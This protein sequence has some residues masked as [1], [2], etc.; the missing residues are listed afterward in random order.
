MGAIKV[1]SYQ[2]VQSLYAG[3]SNQL[4]GIA[5][6]YFLAATEIL[7]LDEFDPELDLLEPFYN[8]WQAALN[9]YAFTIP[10]ALNA[11]VAL[12]DHVIDKAR[13]DASVDAT[14]VASKFTTIDNWIDAAATNG[15]GTNVGRADDV[16]TSFTV[17]SAFATLSNLAGHTI[18]S[19]NIS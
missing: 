6:Y 14:G 17:D 10:S 8:A 12:Q 18:S 3:A 4:S 15:V 9:T 11:V 1:A 16:D 13:T 7:L 19:G 2:T 5:D